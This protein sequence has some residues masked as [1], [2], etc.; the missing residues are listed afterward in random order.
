VATCPRHRRRGILE[1][2]SNS[3]NSALSG[4][5]TLCDLRTNPVSVRPIVKSVSRTFV[6][7]VDGTF[8]VV[9]INEIKCCAAPRALENADEN[10]GADPDACARRC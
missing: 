8:C 9:A 10:D 7:C 5:V 6:Y 3:P 2:G 4:F 1:A